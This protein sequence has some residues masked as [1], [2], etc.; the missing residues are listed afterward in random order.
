M[1]DHAR[2]LFATE[3]RLFHAT[4]V[5]ELLEVPPT[6]VYAETRAGRFPHV[7]V[8]RYRRFRLEA[9]ERGSRSTSG[10]RAGERRPRGDD[11]RDQRRAH[12]TGSLETRD[13]HGREIYYGRFYVAG[14]Q[15][16]RKLGP[17]RLPGESTG[18][19]KTGA[20][21]ALQNLIDAE[22]RVVPIGERVDLQTPASATSSTSTR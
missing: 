5:A 6:W 9:V 12:G 16:K 15:V 8:G 18:L 20:E 4:D 14:R 19:T 1:S 3:R 2:A 21:R 11:E 10:G 13:R 17:K 7:N 22:V